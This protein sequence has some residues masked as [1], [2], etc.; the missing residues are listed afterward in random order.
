MRIL[1][2][3]DEIFVRV[4]IKTTFDWGKHGF[5]I[6]GEAEDGLEAVNIFMKHKPDIVLTDIL[7]PGM[8]GLDF[9]KQVK[10]VN[11]YCRFIILTCHNEFEYM[12]EAMKLGVR[13]YIMKTTVKRDEL[14][15][16]V[17]RVASEIEDE[18]NRMDRLNAEKRENFINRPIVIQKFLNDV[19]D[20]IEADELKIR[21][22][23]AELQ[24]EFSVPNL[25]LVL[26]HVDYYQKL[27]ANCD[28][29]SYDLL[30]FGVSNIAQEIFKQSLSA[31]AAKRNEK[32]IILFASFDNCDDVKQYK[33]KLTAICS[34]VIKSVKEFLNVSVS[35]GISNRI[36]NFEGISE[37]YKS[38]LKAV[39][40]RFFKGAGSISFAEDEGG[41]SILTRELGKFEEQI[42]AEFANFNFEEA[43][44]ILDNL[45]NSEEIKS[46]TDVRQ[47]RNF[48]LNFMF[49]AL[50]VLHTDVF[51][52]DE[53]KDINFNPAVIF[54]CEYVDDLFDYFSGILSDISG[55]LEEKL[56]GKNRSIINKVKDYICQNAG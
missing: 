44:C 51:Y 52:N 26:I 9:I 6:V 41:G 27:K 35:V 25:Y 54:S 2:V 10:G 11:P 20:K 16:I 22:K 17:S 30:V 53:G 21:D 4:G 45:K 14:L 32:E 15:E 40:R 34:D 24:L 39:E 56:N 38:A 18:R 1:I 36:D 3:D 8:N 48:F 23:V 13:D 55:L 47:T 37:G 42:N 19:I 33:Q 49:N 5:E 46:G 12:R 7:M 29:K 31:Y 50:K 43:L 28:P